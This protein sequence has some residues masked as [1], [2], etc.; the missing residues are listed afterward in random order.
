M[1]AGNIGTE[2]L[3]AVGSLA[4]LRGGCG[5]QLPPPP[6]TH[7]FLPPS[8]LTLGVPRAVCRLGCQPGGFWQAV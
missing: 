7:I 5:V 1:G 4:K 6:H 8:S 2:G 3:H